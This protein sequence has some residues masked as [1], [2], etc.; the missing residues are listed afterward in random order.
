MNEATTS[1]KSLS[2][3][4]SNWFEKFLRTAK[5]MKAGSR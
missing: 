3:Q 5:Q 4:T 2:V 1:D